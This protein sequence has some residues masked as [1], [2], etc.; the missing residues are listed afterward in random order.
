MMQLKL[1]L[2]SSEASSSLQKAT[3][4]VLEPTVFNEIKK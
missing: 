4:A 1:G 3:S 2:S